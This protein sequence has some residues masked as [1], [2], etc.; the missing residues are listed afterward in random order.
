MK[1]LARNTLKIQA[2]SLSELIYDKETESKPGIMDNNTW[3][4][5]IGGW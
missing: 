5:I 4:Y 1:L 3:L 2:F